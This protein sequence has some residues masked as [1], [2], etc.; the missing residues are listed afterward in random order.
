M[1]KSELK[2]SI[3]ERILE[4]KC[5]RD[6]EEVSTSSGAGAYNTPYAFKLKKKDDLKEIEGRDY[7]DIIG[8]IITNMVYMDQ[9]VGEKGNPEERKLFRKLKFALEDFNDYMSV[10][11]HIKQN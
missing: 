5:K 8:K 9:Y 1:R 3:R 7:D 4:K 11:D 6:V 10:G 2:Q